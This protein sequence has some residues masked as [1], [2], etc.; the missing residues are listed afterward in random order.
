V[1]QLKIVDSPSG[2]DL[3]KTDTSMAPSIFQ[4]HQLTV[5]DA[6]PVIHFTHYDYVVALLLFLAFC[7]FVWL[8]VSSNKRL[9]QLI[10]DFYTSRKGNRSSKDEYSVSS[11][12]G[13]TLSILFLLTISLFITQIIEYY[14]W[15]I[16]MSTSALYA[17]L[18]IAL[19]VM[20]LLKIGMIRL[21]GFIFKTGKE[22]SEYISA[23]FIF[24]NVLG[25]FMLPVVTCLAFVKQVNPRVFIYTGY[26]I[27]GSFLC[28]RLLKGL[29]IGFGSNRVSKFYL[30]LYLC[31]LEI[32]PFV[33]LIKLFMLY[34]K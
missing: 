23:I 29:V 33:I 1:P 32:I 10:K 13:F 31:T 12:V 3:S 9:N 21:S 16:N 15:I 22:T 11:R 17:S 30:F 8:Y 5:K 14:G 7:L 19:L 25:L 2:I 18:I 27:I 24:I 28:L 6:K 20:Y 34:V 4:N 26:L